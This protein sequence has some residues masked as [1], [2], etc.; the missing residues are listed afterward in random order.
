VKDS[1]PSAID[2]RDGAA[3]A[4]PAS[5]GDPL[6]NALDIGPPFALEPGDG[7]AYCGA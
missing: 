3:D 6:N 1:S 7:A 4:W 5:A 2:P